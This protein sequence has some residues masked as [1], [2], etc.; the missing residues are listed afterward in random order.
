MRLMIVF[1]EKICESLNKNWKFELKF[2]K[3]LKIFESFKE[4]VN[5]N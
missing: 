2:W 4:N 5:K 1:W 3:F